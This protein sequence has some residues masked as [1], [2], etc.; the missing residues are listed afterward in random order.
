MM[1]ANDN[2]PRPI[3]IAERHP[4]DRFGGGILN[5][6][7]DAA[8]DTAPAREAPEQPVTTLVTAALGPKMPPFTGD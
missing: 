5:H 7:E 1:T 6:S 3:E 4:L 2:E 8:R